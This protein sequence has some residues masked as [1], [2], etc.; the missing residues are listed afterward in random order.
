MKK[1]KQVQVVNGLIAG[2]IFA[3]ALVTV[4]T[5]VGDLY[6]PLKDWLKATFY[7]HWIG[8]GVLSATSV[9]LG[10][11]L[12]AIIETEEKKRL[13]EKLLS[14]LSTAVIIGIIVLLLFYY[15]EAFL[16]TH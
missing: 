5:V 13:T 6:S 16:V 3:V 4:L 15:Y 1:A 10:A 12:G 11:L 7:H 14:I 8:K 2:G 9:I